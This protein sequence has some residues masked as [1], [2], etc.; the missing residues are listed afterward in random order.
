MRRLCVF[1]LLWSAC[2]CLNPSAWAAWGSF[3]STGTATAV[4]TPSCAQ[5]STGHVACAIRNGKSAVMVNEFNGTAWG[6]WTALAGAV[7]S[8][9]SCTSDGNGNVICAAMAAG[10][11][12]WTLFNGTTWTKPLKVTASLFS[13]PSCANYAVGQVLCVARNASGG[14]AYTLYN[15][16]TWSA[17]ANLSTTTI[18]QPSCTTDN[19][20]GVICAVFTSGSATEVNRYN[21]SWEGFLNLGG[22]AGGEPNCTSMNQSGNVVCFAKG[23]ASGIYGS[24][25]NGGT[26]VAT[27]WPA[28]SGLSGVVNDNAGCTTQAA[29]QLVCGATSVTDNAFYSDVWNGSSWTGWIKI[30]GSGAGSPACAPLGT[31]QVVCVMLGL[32]NQV[33]SVVGP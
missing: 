26:W 16:T 10:N 24:R 19:N 12:Q 20:G 31:G 18:S 5:L 30:G 4:G 33:T 7:S 2:L 27:N 32:N 28:Y 15:G 29:N 23:Y 13:A 8:D 22:I 11:L 17:I 6:K 14:L 21:G 25:F 1:L 3:I 9:P